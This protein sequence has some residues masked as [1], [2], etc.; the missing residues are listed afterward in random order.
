MVVDVVE[1]DVVDAD[2]SWGVAVVVVVAPEADAPGLGA[3]SD[4]GVVE[5]V[6]VVVGASSVFFVVFL[7]FRSF[8]GL[9]GLAS[10]GTVTS[11]GAA[12][13]AG[14]VSVLFEAGGTLGMAAAE[15][16]FDV[17]DAS[18]G[19]E[20]GVVAE[21]AGLDS[22][23]SFHNDSSE[24]SWSSATAGIMHAWPT[25]EASSMRLAATRTALFRTEISLII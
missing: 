7:V 19:F 17:V 10:A 4:S 20:G 13:A 14:T 15:E 2:E 9:A 25:V 23:S 24:P 16:S 8:F 11:I 5:V 1:V 12:V 21:V 22:D 3:R 18:V 6:E